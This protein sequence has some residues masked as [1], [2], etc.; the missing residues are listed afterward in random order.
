MKPCT[1]IEHQS[2]FKRFSKFQKLFVP[3]FSVLLL[4]QENVLH[5]II[6]DPVCITGSLHCS[7]NWV[8]PLQFWSLQSFRLSEYLA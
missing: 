1:S 6:S 2:L 3:L 5:L 8:F 7:G 4:L